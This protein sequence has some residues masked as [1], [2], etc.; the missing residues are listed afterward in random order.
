VE[1]VVDKRGVYRVGRGNLKE[2]NHL[3]ELGVDVG[4]I[5][6]HILRKQGKSGLDSFGSA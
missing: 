2:R 3:E 1:R 4:I 5:L 6:K